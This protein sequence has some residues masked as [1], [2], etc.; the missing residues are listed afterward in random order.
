M[1]G[2][3]VWDV[4]HGRDARSV[5]VEEWGGITYALERA[6]RRA[7]RRLGD[8]AAHE[9]RRRP[10]GARARVPAHAAA[11][12]ARR[13]ARSRCRIPNNRVELR[14]Y[15][16]RAA[17]A[18][19]LTGGVPAWSWLGAQAAARRRALDALLHQLP[20][21][22]RAR[23]RDGAAHPAALRRPDLLRPA[24]AGAGGAAGRAAHAAAAPERRRV[25]PL[26]R[27]PAGER[28]RAGDDGARSDGARRDGDRRGRVVP[29]RHAGQARRGVRRRAG[30]RRDLR[31]A[32]ARRLSTGPRGGTGALGA[33]RTA[34]VP[35][36]RGATAPAIR[37]D[38]ATCGA[39]PISPGCS[40]VIS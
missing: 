13:G 12:R 23:P 2:T 33:V 34:L 27:P 32:A 4:I 3:F 26:L 38:A 36:E 15:T 37:P 24:L 35:A 31:P 10:R 17:H 20:E 7:A 21:R 18:S 40:P 25:V 22:L 16:R 28:G 39:Q 1:I 19:V 14:Y 9:G 29:V 5:P 11:H 30:L 6:R 8:R